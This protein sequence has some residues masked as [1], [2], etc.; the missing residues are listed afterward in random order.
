MGKTYWGEGR[1]NLSSVKKSGK[2]HL[3]D[4]KIFTYLR[5]VHKSHL[6]S[7]SNEGSCDEDGNSE[8]CPVQ[9]QGE[10]R[11]IIKNASPFTCDNRFQ[12]EPNSPTNAGIQGQD[13]Q[14]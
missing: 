2:I 11:L 9:I 1:K 8:G 13:K 12:E 7:C 6:E 14:G 4:G 5:R 10:K 3:D